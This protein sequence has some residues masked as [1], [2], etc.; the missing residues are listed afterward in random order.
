SGR[1]ARDGVTD[2]IRDLGGGVLLTSRENLAKSRSGGL[3]LVANARLT[4]KLSYTISGNGAW[5]EISASDL[6]F[7]ATR[8]AWTV[9]G[10]AA[11]NVTATPKDLLQ[12]SGFA[13][14]KRLTPQGYREPIQMVNLGYRRKVSDKLSFVVTAQDVLKGFE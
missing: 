3:E 8:S 6:G 13:I 14:G 4:P 2:V 12:I 11:L 5:N 9:S 1:D 10:Y 7:A